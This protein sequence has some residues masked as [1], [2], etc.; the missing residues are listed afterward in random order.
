MSRWGNRWLGGTIGGHSLSLAFARQLPQRGSRER[1]RGRV[2]FN[3]P[4]GNRKG[5]GDFHRPYER[6]FPFIEVH[7]LSL[8]FARQLPQR[9]SRERLRGTDTIQ[10][11]ARKPGGC[12]RFSSPLRKA[13]SIHRGTLPQSRVRS[14]APSGREPGMG[15][16]HS[17]S[18][19]E[20]ATLRAIFIA[21]T[22]GVFHSSG[23]TPSVSRSLDS[24]LR[25]G[26]GNGCVPFNQPPGN[27]NVAGD[28]HRP[29]EG[30]EYLS[31]QKSSGF[32]RK[33]DTGWGRAPTYGNQLKA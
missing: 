18:R 26:A 4:P 5:A 25:E 3:V 30:S 13:F 33:N 16:Y 29:Y 23:D 15:A 21:P 31:A 7:S 22:K 6:R 19:P 24:S 11:A 9:G 12:G 32:H 14:T 2:P 20:T 17:T 10:C 28:F 8:A 1:L 27:R